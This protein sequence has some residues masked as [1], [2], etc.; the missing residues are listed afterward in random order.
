VGYMY[1]NIHRTAAQI[2]ANRI[3]SFL[4]MYYLQQSISEDNY[5]AAS[6]IISLANMT[7]TLLKH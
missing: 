5:D 6:C 7:K 2:T 4:C 3:P 1:Q